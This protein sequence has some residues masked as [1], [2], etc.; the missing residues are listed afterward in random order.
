[1][2]L[3]VARDAAARADALKLLAGETA[4]GLMLPLAH[5]N[6]PSVGGEGAYFVICPAPPGPSLAAT[7][8]PWPEAVLLEHVL[9]P[10]ATALGFLQEH[11]QTHRGIRLDNLFHTG[12]GNGP[13][14]S[15]VVLGA[16]WAAPPAMHQPVLFEPPYSAICH[17]AARGAGSIA[18]D[19]YA[20]G[21]VLITLAL[22][23]LPMAGQ[24][25]AAIIQ[26]K[27]EFGSF[28]A[29]AGE[30][31]LP[32]VIADLA[33][34]ML[35]ED[36]DH[37]TPLPLLLDPSAARGRRVATRPPRRA[38]RPLPIGGINVSESRGLAYAIAVEPEAAMH[39]LTS[40]AAMAWLRRGLGDAN[41]AV[42]LEELVRF[43]SGG[44]KEGTEESAAALMAAVAVI[45]PLAPLCWRGFSVWPDGIG[46]ALASALSGDPGTLGLLEEMVKCEAPASWAM[47]RADRSDILTARQAGRIQ[48]TAL[49]VRGI[50][51][52]VPRLAYLLNSLLP[53]GSPLMMGRWVV[54]AAD[55]LP[56]LEAAVER[57][58]AVDLID[59]HVAA[60][61]ATRAD[62]RFDRDL[63]A[64]GGRQT[65]RILAQLRLL[66]ELQA[67]FCPMPL[68]RLARR[69]ADMARPLVLEWHNR[70]KRTALDESLEKLAGAGM[71]APMLNLIEDPG[72]RSADNEGASKAAEE[73][74][75][76]DQEL[77]AIK[78]SGSGRNVL[79]AR[80]GQE[81]AAGL[82][83]AAAAVALI[84]AAFG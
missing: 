53:C 6:G 65:G 34:G 15:G 2:A 38:Q 47:F 84:T 31:K 73:L 62:R 40:G 24:T 37:R 16:A 21:V 9:R 78:H 44:I 32:A 19:V 23:R 50:A 64:L 14:V 83:L 12:A 82:G 4:E 30:E 39:A 57:D 42:R 27:L 51:G 60:F 33:R 7:L 67:R 43:R 77:A 76:I 29:I 52:G 10:I 68:P 36:P 75:R 3:R 35:A 59:G 79:A 5:G 8:R 48:R 11:G 80:I 25:D 66:S 22:G 49:Q 26:R 81:V 58:P 46:T 61:I 72:G 1:M 17:P 13:G 28:A 69:V 74:A 56:A 54:R 20:L 41:L 55:L 71:I 18:D 70:Q 45:D 63:A